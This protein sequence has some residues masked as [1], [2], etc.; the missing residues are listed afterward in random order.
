MRTIRATTDWMQSILKLA[1]L[2]QSKLIRNWTSINRPEVTRICSSSLLGTFNVG[3]FLCNKRNVLLKPAGDYSAYKKR[4]G[5]KKEVKITKRIVAEDK[6]KLQILQRTKVT[7]HN[8]KCVWSCI[9]CN[10]ETACLP[11][12]DSGGTHSAG[13]PTVLGTHRVNR[14]YHWQWFHLCDKIKT[15]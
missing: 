14:P 9:S 15:P 2:D 1:R 13:E 5:M 7:Y 10:D 3:K 12:T 6:Q 11:A 8:I 4:N